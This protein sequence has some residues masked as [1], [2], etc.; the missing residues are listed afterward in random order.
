[1][2]LG[3]LSDTHGQAQRCAAALRFLKARGATHFV[4]CGDV[5]GD[6]VFEI[7]A[8]EPVWFAWGNMD[9]PSPSR[10]RYLSALGLSA[11]A[12]VPARF[13]FG[14][15]RCL[16]CHGHEPW[17][18]HLPAE[19]NADYLFHGHTHRIRD[20][21]AHGARIINPGALH[22]AA[23]Y[24]VATLDVTRDAL[25]FWNLSAALTTGAVEPL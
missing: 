25:T 16:L 18:A 15:R 11:P 4:H 12:D 24:T 7:L 14:G 21:R 22:R 1:M 6:G 9:D 2:M 19:L 20:E 23:I 17:F 10:I 3:L 13:E 8:G 5:G